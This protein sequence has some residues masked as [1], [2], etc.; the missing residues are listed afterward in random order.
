MRGIILSRHKIK[1]YGRQGKILP[2]GMEEEHTAFLH[3]LLSNDIKGMKEGSLLYNLWLRQN[4]TPIEDFFVYKLGNYYLLDTEGDATRIIQEFSRLKLSLRVYFEDLTQSLS[5]A[6]IFG[7]GA[8]EFVKERFGVTLEEGDVLEL[9][10]ILLARNHIRLREEGYDILGS[11]EKLKELLKGVEMISS[12]G[13]EDIRIEKLVPRIRK[14]L[15]EGFSPLEA[16]VLNYA[17]SLTKG[18][19]V[20]QEAIARVYYRG[21]TP[22]VLAK[23]EARNVREGDKIKEGEKDIGIITSVNSRGDL[24][25][26]YILRAKANIGKVLPC[27]AGEVKLLELSQP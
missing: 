22:R 7:E 24:A 27:S 26:G 18:C 6:F 16:G 8:R 19:Y 25:L 11:M 14:E 1:V 3:N 4:G 15:R 2:K 5:H 9:E 12:E 23:F 20:G 13:F 21:R 17:I 10:D